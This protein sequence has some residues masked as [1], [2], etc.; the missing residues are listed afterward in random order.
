MWLFVGKVRRGAKRV[1]RLPTNDS[2]PDSPDETNLEQGKPGARQGALADAGPANESGIKQTD[3]LP[4]SIPVDPPRGASH[5]ALTVDPLAPSLSLPVRKHTFILNTEDLLK[6][7]PTSAQSMK[8]K[9]QENNGVAEHPGNLQIENDM[10]DWGADIKMSFVESPKAPHELDLTS[11]VFKNKFEDEIEASDDADDGTEK[12]IIVRPREYSVP[13]KIGGN[14]RAGWSTIPGTI[15]CE[16]GLRKLNQDSY[17]ALAPF[18]GSS[19]EIFVAVFDGHGA[20]GRKVSQFVR[21]SLPAEIIER[22]KTRKAE[23][24]ATK[25]SDGEKIEIYDAELRK[26]ALKHAFIQAESRLRD[27]ATGIDHQFSGTTGVGV[28]LV[29]QLAYAACTGDSRAIIGRKP[30]QALSPKTPRGW[31]GPPAILAVSMTCDQKP[32]RPDERKRVRA[33]GGRITRWKKNVG[34]LRVWLP[35]DWIPGLAMT[36]SIGDTILTEFGVTPEPEVTV[37]GLGPLDSFIV[38]ASDGVWEFMTSDEVALFV[39]KERNSGTTP[40]VAAS[41]LVS[42]AVRRWGQHEVMVDDITAVVLFID[43][44]TQGSEAPDQPHLVMDDGTLMP[45]DIRNNENKGFT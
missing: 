15:G 7:S 28:W 18:S 22:Y 4:V 39:W 33:A 11:T 6:V 19:R 13:I 40:S 31:R 43:F 32:T 1:M 9:A 30:L 26:A 5:D 16:Q 23:R 34:P 45:L 17:F 42:E 29:G 20:E 8:A 35:D 38:L 25:P 3:G 27:I 14:S 41:R 37:T 36:R 2:A 44:E 24:L 10:F 21:N 12:Q